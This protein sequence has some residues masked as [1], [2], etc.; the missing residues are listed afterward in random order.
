MSTD[1]FQISPGNVSVQPGLKAS[2]L[3]VGGAEVGCLMPYSHLPLLLIQR[4]V[5]HPGSIWIVMT[6]RG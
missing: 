2:H 4:L 3:D 6:W 5:A 1:R